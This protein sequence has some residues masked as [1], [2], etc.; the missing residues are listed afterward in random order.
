MV[1]LDP[2]EIRALSLRRTVGK[3]RVRTVPLGS[4][5][6]RSARDLGIGFGD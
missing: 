3:G 4:D 2:P 5:V 6:I 1:A